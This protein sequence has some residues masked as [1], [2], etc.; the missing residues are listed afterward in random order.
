MKKMT[1][2]LLGENRPKL[3]KMMVSQQTST[4]RKG[5]GREL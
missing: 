2:A 3:A 1:V 4:T 5:H